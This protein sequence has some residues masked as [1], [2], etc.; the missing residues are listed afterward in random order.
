[1]NL[2]ASAR[3]AANPNNAAGADG[4]LGDSGEA[5]QPSRRGG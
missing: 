3:I 5:V 4:D 2:T 1:M